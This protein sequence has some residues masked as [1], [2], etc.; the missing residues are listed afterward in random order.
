M[1]QGSSDNYRTLFENHTKGTA[2][3]N[4]RLRDL[5]FRLGKLEIVAEALW[6]LLR[7]NTGLSE[8][9]LLERVAEIDLRDGR[10]D[11]KRKKIPSVECPKCG[12]MNSKQH[13]ACLYCGETILLNPFD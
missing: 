7:E 10:Y 6:E 4:S 13:G 8:V 3:T 11:G 5:E 12:R 9:D 1:P 2:G